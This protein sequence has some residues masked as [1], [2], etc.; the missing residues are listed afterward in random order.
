[1]GNKHD[2]QKWRG[3]FSFVTNSNVK[4]LE[5]AKKHR[6]LA[7]VESKHWNTFSYDL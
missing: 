6:K 4:K 3:N 1:M 7:E 2:R 5:M